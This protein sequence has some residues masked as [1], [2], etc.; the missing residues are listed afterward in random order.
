MSIKGQTE[1]LSEQHKLSHG[2]IGIFGHNAKNHDSLVCR[3]AKKTMSFLQNKYP[4]L[5]FRYRSSISKEEINHALQDIDNELGVTLFLQNS[6]IKPDGGLIEVMDDNNKWRVVLVSG[7]KFQGKDIDNIKNGKLVGKN[8]NQDLMAAGNAIERSH[9]NISEI[10][11]YMLGEKY[12]PYILFLEGSNFLTEDVTIF[13][14]DGREIILHYNSG[15]LN[16]LD[17][18]T[19]ANYGLPLNKNLCINKF[20]QCQDRNIM[21]QAASI[22]TQGNGDHW[23]EISLCEIMIDLA[24]TAIKCLTTDL[25]NQLV[26][27]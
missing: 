10:A 26:R 11:N 18:L 24:E 9:K 3:G 16:R 4:Q 6:R 17:R 5:K 23:N 25:F 2:E 15:I 8:N 19:A 20:V 7:A 14:P 27:E 21:L 1:R 22:F 12:F 13:R